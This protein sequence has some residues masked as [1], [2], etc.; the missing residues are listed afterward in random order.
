[1]YSYTNLKMGTNTFPV[2]ANKLFLHD[3]C[4]CVIDNFMGSQCDVKIKPTNAEQTYGTQ[5]QER[6]N[7]C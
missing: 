4:F 2:N 6:S 5:P 3:F 7:N 1:M